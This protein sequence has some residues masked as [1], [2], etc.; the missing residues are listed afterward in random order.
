MR[1]TSIN[2]TPT[3]NYQSDYEGTLQNCVKDFERWC[4]TY[5]VI[6]ATLMEE[7]TG[8]VVA[9]YDNVCGCEFYLAKEAQ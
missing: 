4:R 6:W 8:Y 7:S 2:H 3:S 5:D 9:Y 1:Y